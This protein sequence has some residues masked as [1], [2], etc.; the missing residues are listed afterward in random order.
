MSSK[1]V[2]RLSVLP[3]EIA[4][5]ILSSMPTKDAVQT[6]ILSKSWRYKWRLVTNLDFDD[7]TF[8]DKNILIK[9]GDWVMN[10]CKSSHIQL[11]R[12]HF[13]K[14][15]TLKSRVS[16]WIDKAVR[17][18]VRELDI[19]VTSLSLKLPLSMFTCK[20]LTK[21]RLDF[22]DYLQSFLTD[23]PLVYLPCLKSL[24]ISVYTDHYINA[25]Y[26]LINGCPMLENLSLHI[27]CKGNTENYIFNIPSLKRLKLKWPH[28]TSVIN[29]V[30]LNVPNLEYLFIGG[31]LCSV[32]VM[33]DLSS[34][35]EASVSFR[36]II[37]NRHRL[38]VELLNGLSGVKSLF[39]QNVSFLFTSPLPIFPNMKHLKLKNFQHSR[40]ILQFLESCPELKHLY[41]E[42]KLIHTWVEPKSVPACML[43]NL[44]TI[45]ISICKL[46]KRDMLFLKYMLKNSAVL[47]N[48][49][50]TC[51]E[52]RNVE[53]ETWFCANLRK[54]PK[55]LKHCEIHFHGKYWSHSTIS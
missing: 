1:N 46:W 33:E 22:G 28:H 35:V 50:I 3:E 34:L 5:H 7:D 26:K 20:T 21:L 4:S 41:I 52:S 19:E 32:F 51:R 14:R 37:F 42:E 44:T 25:F 39:V 36:E 15:W 13:S 31:M 16:N 17:L 40:S 10:V 48:I 8:H 53:E 18:N 27:M 47:K 12:L 2:D 9:F 6:S 30:F 55:A 29:K 45:K 54:L 24:D 38:L 43:T 23:L 49:T 11:F